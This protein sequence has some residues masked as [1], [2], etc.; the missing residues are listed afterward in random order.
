MLSIIMKKVR[1]FSRLFLFY[2]QAC[3]VSKRVLKAAVPVR[4]SGFA[5]KAGLCSN[6]NRVQKKAQYA[7]FCLEPHGTIF[8]LWRDKVIF[9]LKPDKAMLCLSPD[10][11]IFLPEAGL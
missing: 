2:G 1:F 9:C 3:L 4:L 5:A 6:C 11:A 8:C 10:K 7:M